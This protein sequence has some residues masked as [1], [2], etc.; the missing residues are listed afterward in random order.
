VIDGPTDLS[1]SLEISLT[2][3]WLWGLSSW[4][5]NSES[6]ESTFSLVR[7]VLRLPLPRRLLTV[8]KFTTSLL[9]LFFVQPLF[10]NSV[11]NCNLYILADFWSKF[12]LLYWAASKLP[13]LLDTVLKFALFSVSDLKDEKLIKKQTY[14]KTETYKLYSRDLWIF[15]PNIIRIDPYHFEPYRFKVGPFFWDTV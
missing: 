15:L 3:W 7:A 10:R 6:T 12:C 9:T 4:L 8:P 11:I 1:A 2:V 14:M 13:H 5:S